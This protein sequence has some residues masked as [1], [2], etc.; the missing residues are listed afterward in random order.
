VARQHENELIQYIR[1]LL[2]EPQEWTGYL[3]ASYASRY[4]ANRGPAVRL[5][6]ERLQA[7]YA[8]RRAAITAPN[9]TASLVCALQALG[10]QGPVLTPSLT[11]TATAQALLMAGC[12]PVFCEVHPDTWELDPQAVEQALKR[13][14]I[15]AILH[16]RAYGFG[17]DLAP[18]EALARRERIPLIVDAAAG[19]GGQASI[20]AH[21]G[22]QG[23]VEIFSLHATK[24]FAIGEG[25]VAFVPLELAERFRSTSN[26]GI[27]QL[28]VVE[29]GLNSKLSDFQ[30]AVG[31]AVLDK[32]DAYI[33]QRRKIVTYY[34]SAISKHARVRYA[35]HPGLS[36][37]QSYPVLL[38]SGVDVVACSERAFALGL[39]IKRGYH[40]PL[41]RTAYFGSFA[42][43]ALPVTDEVST[44]TVCLPVYSDM[45]M[46]T[47]GRVVELFLK[48]LQAG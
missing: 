36:P 8:R 42:A 41:H 4:F 28:D 9:A 26:F 17:H 16:V 13:S 27:R 33:E 43:A 23:D 22:Q 30:A 29:R 11:F 25:G 18:L 1:P 48:A 14:E 12:T 34:H 20:A 3:A 5:F 37:W 32:I 40:L 38:E 19:L 2:P 47:A 35:P 24:V 15:K 21:V 6:E 39:E 7:K 45:S 10:I 31:L 44:H 46:Q